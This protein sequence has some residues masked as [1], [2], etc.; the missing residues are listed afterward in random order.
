MKRLSFSEM[1][2]YLLNQLSSVGFR[3]IIDII[4]VALAFYYAFKFMRERRAGKLA[5]GI[6]LLVALLLLS[7]LLELSSLKFILTNFFQIGLIAII[8]LFSPELRS[9]LEKI[10]TGS[11]KSFRSKDAQK[12]EYLSE[13]CAAAE[14]LS[15]EKTGALIVIERSTRL[16]DIIKTGTVIDAQPSSFLICN[17][18]YPKAPLHDGALII[19]EGRLHAAGCWLPLSTNNDIIKNLGTRHRAGIG[20]SENSD[21]VILIVSEETGIISVAVDGELRRGFSKSTLA[22][23]LRSLV[24]DEGAVGKIKTKTWQFIKKGGDRNEDK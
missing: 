5:L 17:I 1:W 7:D 4:I 20:M 12:D 10:G 14:S 18:F 23:Y 16:G 6:V 24:E 15:L 22:E 13:V 8:V 9:A 3:D 11:V 21:A 19:R 2:Y